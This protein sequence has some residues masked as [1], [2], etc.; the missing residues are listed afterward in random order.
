MKNT[1][2][3]QVFF[4]HPQQLSRTMLGHVIWRNPEENILPEFFTILSIE[5]VR[6]RNTP[7]K[8]CFL[9]WMHYDT[10]LLK[11]HVEQVGCRAPYQQMYQKFP[12]CNTLEQMKKS[13]F[14]HW[15][16]PTDFY[17]VPCQV[18]PD[19]PYTYTQPFPNKTTGFTISIVYSDNV[20]TVKQSQA[21]DVHCLIGNMGG[22][23]GL[24]MGK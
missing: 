20:K 17:L 8:P 1:G 24:F 2:N 9:D 4:N 19:V 21:V 23:I 15:S 5:T 10:F 22:Y 12:M 11:K 6:R 13:V 18:I 3:V 16:L 14:D 7:N